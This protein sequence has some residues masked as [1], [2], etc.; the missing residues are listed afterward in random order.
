MVEGDLFREVEED[1]R[2]EQLARAW[3]KYGIYVLGLAALIVVVA[4]GMQIY[5]WWQYKRSS[6]AGAA[7]VNALKLGEDGKQAE[8]RAALEKLAREA[9]RGYALL[10]TLRAAAAAVDAGKAGEAVTLY[11]S[12]ANDAFADE[13]LRSFALIQT[14]SLQVDTLS[15]GDIAAKLKSLNVAGNAWRHSARE[16]MGLAYFRAGKSAEAEQLFQ[17][18]A[19]DPEAPQ[20]MRRRAQTMLALLV[21]PL[22]TKPEPVKEPSQNEAKTQ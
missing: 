15:A 17:D 9:P 13:N 5:D 12:V 1:L 7:Y 14:A 2:R 11:Q 4:A 19:A 16:L 20:E 22:D 3:D 10:A 6:E 8:M 21:S 18:I